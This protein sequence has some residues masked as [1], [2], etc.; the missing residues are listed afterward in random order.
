MK[1]TI[2]LDQIRVVQ[3]VNSKGNPW[4]YLEIMDTRVLYASTYDLEASEEFKSYVTRDEFGQRV[5]DTDSLCNMFR[6]SVARV[7]RNLIVDDLTHLGDTWKNQPDREIYHNE[8]RM[9]EPY[10]Y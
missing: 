1:R 7:L 4:V 2:D 3:T 8:P 5:V 10:E 9:E 6:Y